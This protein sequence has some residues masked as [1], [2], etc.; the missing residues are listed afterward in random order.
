MCRQRSRPVAVLSIELMT[1]FGFAGGSSADHDAALCG[2]SGVIARIAESSLKD[3]SFDAAL[4]K[5]REAIVAVRGL[6]FSRAGAV[7][8][9]ID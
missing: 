5:I 6:Y 9:P 7:A 1:R 2:I 4:S 8:A 3:S